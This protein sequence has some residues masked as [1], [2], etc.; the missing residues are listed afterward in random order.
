MLG[1]PF[2]VNSIARRVRRSDVDQRRVEQSP[3]RSV[4]A[5]PIVIPPALPP[6][7]PPAARGDV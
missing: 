6:C 4:I 1:T 7:P 5:R 3:G 2:I